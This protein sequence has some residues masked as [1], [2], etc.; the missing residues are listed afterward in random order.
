MATKT[1]VYNKLYTDEEWEIVNKV[2]KAIIQDFLEEYQQRKM[3]KS[4]LV[5]YANNLRILMIFINRYCKNKSIL[6]LGKR[7]FRR[8]SIWLS[9]DLHMSNARTN[10]I[11]SAC[12]SMLTYCE[13]SDEWEYDNNISKKVKGLPKERV[14]SD[15]EDFF[16]SFDQIMKIRER[17]LEIGE[18]QLCVLHMILFDSGARRNEVAQVKKQGLLDGNKTNVVIGKRGKQFPLVYLDD[19][20]E[21]IRK[22]L[23]TRGEDDIDCLWIIGDGK[24]KREATYECLY[25]MVMKIRKVLCELE[26]KELNIFPHSYR[27]SRTEVLLQGQDTRIIDKNTGLPM[28]FTL[29]QVQTFLH[30]ENPSTTQGYAKDHS[31]DIIN[32]MFNF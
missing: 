14:H 26:E 6:D 22:Y 28:K 7:D 16:M 11:L 5:Q 15:D 31:E 10:S 25:D 18:M 24:N 29:E 4:T 23:E 19:T 9:D 21:L 20:K 17:L 32:E 3:K 12:R 13:N 8:L 30:H 1:R 2:N 27:H